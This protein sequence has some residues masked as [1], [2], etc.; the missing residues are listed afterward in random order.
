MEEQLFTADE[1]N[2]LIPRLE[3]IIERMQRHGRAIREG[4][5]A[6]AAELGESSQSVPTERLLEQRPELRDDAI[7]IERLLREIEG[8]GGQLKG[9]DLGLVDFP[10]EINGEIVLLC[11]QYGEKEV[12]HYHSLQEGFAGRQPLDPE[13]P[14]PPYLQ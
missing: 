11:W 3:A 14:G 13:R 7:E 9:L 4:A 6:L 8:M 2:E 12:T 1:V 5:E 10:G